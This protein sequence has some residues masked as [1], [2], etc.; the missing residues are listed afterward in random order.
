[1]EGLGRRA[2]MVLCD[3]GVAQGARPREAFKIALAMTAAAAIDHALLAKDRLQGLEFQPALC[4]FTVAYLCL[5]ADGTTST[6]FD[7]SKQRAEG[8][9]AG[10]VFAS[11]CAGLGLLGLE[12]AQGPAAS[13]WA[14]S[15]LLVAFVCAAAFVRGSSSYSYAGTVAAFT[16]PVIMLAPPLSAD[17][18]EEQERLAQSRIEQTLLGISVRLFERELKGPDEAQNAKP[19][20]SIHPVTKYYTKSNKCLLRS[21]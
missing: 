19:N 11:L 10:A 1:M 18:P 20:Q 5:G 17:D 2:R 4:S 8:T 3:S 16:A 6:S 13:A 15:F 7:T 21:N 14:T 12:E 9:L